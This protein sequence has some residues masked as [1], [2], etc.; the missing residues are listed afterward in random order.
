[1]TQL[2]YIRHPYKS[3]KAY[4]YKPSHVRMYTYNNNNK[5]KKE[6]KIV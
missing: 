2:L 6:G 4:M 5:E 1:M 3:L